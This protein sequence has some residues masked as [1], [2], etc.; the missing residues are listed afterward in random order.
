MHE[1]NKREVETLALHYEDDEDHSPKHLSKEAVDLTD[2][3]L[4]S[5]ELEIHISLDLIAFC[6]PVVE[7][8]LPT[9]ELKHLKV[10]KDLR[11]HCG[12]LL[13]LLVPRFSL[14]LQEAVKLTCE[15]EDNDDNAE[16]VEVSV[17]QFLPDKDSAELVDKEERYQH[18]REA[19]KAPPE[20]IELLENLKHCS[21]SHGAFLAAGLHGQHLVEDDLF[22]AVP[23]TVHFE[24]GHIS[25]DPP[26][27]M[28]GNFDK[29][30][31]T[32][33][34]QDV[35]CDAFT[36]VIHDDFNG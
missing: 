11:Q 5:L 26:A 23:D 22:N 4:L 2:H 9:V 12:I 36:P 24:S 17:S 28:F 25:S 1:A 35:R 15:Q 30:V 20:F 3:A 29:E 18:T 27:P 10:V 14:L 16:A 31:G 33:N 34:G 13:T 7:V 8:I 6:E 19:P 32:S 21:F